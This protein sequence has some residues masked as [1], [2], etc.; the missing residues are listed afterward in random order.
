MPFVSINLESE[1]KTDNPIMSILAWYEKMR[2][3]KE[4]SKSAIPCLNGANILGYE[5][6]SKLRDESKIKGLR[7]IVVKNCE[8]MIEP[9]S[10]EEARIIDIVRKYR[11]GSI[12]YWFES[13]FENKKITMGKI[14]SDTI[15]EMCFVVKG[16]TWVKMSQGDTI[17]EVSEREDDE[18]ES[19]VRSKVIVDAAGNAVSYMYS[20][21]TLLVPC[22]KNP[23]KERKM[24]LAS[25]GIQVSGME[26]N[27]SMAGSCSKE[28]YIIAGNY[29][30]KSTDL[31][32]ANLA[33]MKIKDWRE[34]VPSI[35]KDGRSL[36]SEGID[37]TILANALFSKDGVPAFNL[38]VVGPKRN[39]KTAALSFLVKDMMGGSIVSGSSSTGRGWLVSHKEGVAPSKMFSEK[40]CLMIDEALKFKSGEDQGVVIRVK[41]HFVAHMEIIERKGMEIASGNGVISG[42]MACSLFCVDNPDFY[43]LNALGKAYKLQD[44]SFRRWSFLWMDRDPNVEITY[45]TTEQSHRM[46]RKKFTEYGG[47]ES[48]KALMLLSRR[49]CQRENKNADEKWVESMRNKLKAEVDTYKLFPEINVLFDLT[50]DD[51]HKLLLSEEMKEHIDI[52]MV[53]A[54]QAAWLSAAAMRGWEVYNSYEDYKM[55][56]DDRQKLIAELVI[57]EIFKG[58]LK[59]LFPGIVEWIG[60]NMGVKRSNL[61]GVG[62]R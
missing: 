22:D 58:R 52:D 41:N 35:N 61:Y 39:Q 28:K 37:A 9:F 10:V 16:F 2:A 19:E 13:Q 4:I 18:S 12:M 62:K 29:K 21:V 54:M 7:M 30:I 38:L 49:I 42:K 34:L 26:I 15:S 20:P 60:D 55:V 8:Y 43:V 36:F 45:L 47:I 40:H 17:E 48:V 57:R 50:R 27:V 46:M 31:T 11:D 33:L 44:A 59:L 1:E 5:F 14:V 23:V 56:Y 24:I 32:Q 6:L 53:D 51:N 25:E 3:R